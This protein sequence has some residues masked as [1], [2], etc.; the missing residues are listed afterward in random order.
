M[1]K[2]RRQR[3]IPERLNHY[4][5]VEA[6]K[7]ILS[8]NEG[9]GIC[10]WAFSNKYKNDEQ[11]I[12]MGEY[13]LKRIKTDCSIP[14]DSILHRFGGYDNSASVSFME[15]AVNQHMLDV[16]GHCRLEFDLRDLSVSPLTGGLI[17]CEY[18]AKD[19][20]KA[21][22][23]EYCE[24]IKSVYNSI[25]FSQKLFG[26]SS[27]FAFA[28]VVRFIMME[29]DVIA[30]VFAMKEEKWS[31]E[32]EWRRVVELKDDS[33]I[34]YFNGKPYVKS[35]LDKEKLEGKTI[36]CTY[37]TMAKARGDAVE[38]RKY[39]LE[40]GYNAKVNVRILVPLRKYIVCG[41][42]IYMC[43]FGINF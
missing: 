32:K 5:S 42:I 33:E 2:E 14:E 25:P 35:Y 30:K 19:E 36:V 38:I 23:D 28:F 37:D 18:V 40:R 13:V 1:L 10:F 7:S 41:K 29:C 17:D 15:G 31:E 8:D 6:L 9:K 27:S 21:Y 12:K 22:A 4:T 43:Q 3:R 11:E 24:R 20:L 16:Y 39:I 34:L 26:I